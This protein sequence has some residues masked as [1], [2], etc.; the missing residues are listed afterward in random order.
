MGKTALITGM[1]MDSKTLT[2]ILLSKGYRV[3]LTHRRNTALDVQDVLGIFDNDLKLFFGASLDTVFMDITDQ[4]SVENAILAVLEK[5][6]RIDE[7]YHLAAQSH[8]GDSFKMEILSVV[9][10]GHSAFFIL[11]SLRKFSKETRFYFANTSECFGGDPK[12]CPF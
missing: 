4:N 8:V 6:G 9:T 2:H 12:N 10:N 1:G 11:E 7:L 5:Y 3:I